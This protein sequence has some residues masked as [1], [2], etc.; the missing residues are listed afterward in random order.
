M[1]N[2][3]VSPEDGDAWWQAWRKAS[4]VLRAEGKLKLW[5]TRID[6][7]GDGAPE[8][9]LRLDNPFTTKVGGCGE[10]GWE[11]EK[12]S[13]AYRHG[14]LYMLEAANASMR[15]GF[16]LVA[17]LI[18]DILHFAGGAYRPGC[19]QRVPRGGLAAWITVSPDRPTHRRHAGLDGLFAVQYGRWRMLQ[20]RLGTHRALSASEG[21]GRTVRLAVV[22]MTCNRVKV[23]QL[24]S[25]SKGLGE[26]P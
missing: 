23:R 19:L 11:A 10:R 20:H 8:I 5:R 26:T 16:N 9:I 6:V 14:R 13:C 12:N 4:E 18:T 2:G 15:T 17:P 22:E 24:P 1:K 3:S 21:V 25:L 7:D